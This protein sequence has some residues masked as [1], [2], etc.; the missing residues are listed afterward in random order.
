ME[1]AKQHLD[2][3]LFTNRLEAMLRFWQLEVGLPFQELLPTGGGNQQHRHGMNGSVLKL[4]HSRDV[5]P[6][7]GPSGIAELIIATPGTFYH[8]ADPD[9]NRVRLVPPGMHGI[10][11]IAVRLRVRSLEASAR[12]YGE[13]LGF[14]PLGEGRFRCGTSQVWLE[15]DV[16]QP[17]TGELRGPGYRYLTVQVWDVDAEH[18]GVLARG[19][20]EGAP[21]STLGE[22]ARIS[23]VRDH[24]GNWLEISQRTSLTG[25]LGAEDA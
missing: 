20:T 12:Y 7:N 4:N 17:P 15:E 13:A 9:G 23:F 11:G 10:E 1:L 8:L 22:T 6:A 14:E 24:D 19:G 25:A 2:V 3:G 21:P 18:A 5:L 16:S